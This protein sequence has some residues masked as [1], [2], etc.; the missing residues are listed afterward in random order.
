M[1]ES[2]KDEI[3]K[4]NEIDNLEDKHISSANI[5]K[6]ILKIIKIILAIL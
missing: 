1:K 4:N 5:I 6:I 3:K 2:L